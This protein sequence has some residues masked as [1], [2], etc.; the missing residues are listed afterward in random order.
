M[1][2]KLDRFFQS[3]SSRQIHLIAVS[4]LILCALLSFSIVPNKISQNNWLDTYMYTSLIYD[5]GNVVDRY[6]ATYYPTRIAHIIPA[7]VI[8][9]IFGYEFGYYIHKATF[10]SLSVV[11]VY[12]IA[13][14]FL[15]PVFSILL[16][17]WAAFNP[18]LI[19]AFLWDHYEGSALLYL[20]LAMAFSLWGLRCKKSSFGFLGVA[21]SFFALSVN[22]NPTLLAIGGSFALSWIY[23]QLKSE[24]KIKDLI[25]RVIFFLIGFCL[26]YSVMISYMRIN[27]P[28][29]G[30]FFED[31]T[32]KTVIW[33]V[34]GGAKNWFFPFS[35]LM[36]NKIYYALSPAFLL[37][38]LLFLLL[39]TRRLPNLNLLVAAIINLAVLCAFYAYSHL[40]VKSDMI[41]LF[42]YNI[43]SLPAMMF[44][45][46]ALFANVHS[47][48]LKNSP[49][50]LVTAT[51]F[52]L[53]ISWC[54]YPIFHATLQAISWKALIIIFVVLS[55]LLLL[56][57]SLIK[58]IATFMLLVVAALVPYLQGTYS[59]IHNAND[60][61]VT[62]E[63]DVYAGAINLIDIVKKYAPID[64]G[65]VGFWYENEWPTSSLNSIQST[66]LWGYSRIHSPDPDL[67]KIGMPSMTDVT[68]E[69]IFKYRFL[70]L[71]S[72]KK[73]VVDSGFKAISKLPL[74]VFKIKE[75]R[76][77]GKK[78]GY[79]YLI[80]KIKK[81]GEMPSRPSDELGLE[82]IKMDI[83]RLHSNPNWKESELVMSNDGISVKTPDKPWNYAA[84]FPLDVKSQCNNKKWCWI[85]VTF[86]DISGTPTISLFNLKENKIEFETKL[87]SKFDY[88]EIFFQL[89]EPE[90]Y[91]HLLIRNSGRDSA[92]EI[93]IKN[94]DLITSRRR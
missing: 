4:F 70:V 8:H 20:L 57:N 18:Q 3:L 87:K 29:Y 40:V 94:I 21:G 30:V 26:C 7:S 67:D 89:S 77:Q 39:K 64:Y 42:Y 14:A 85:R 6:G 1:Y 11:A 27:Y 12:F 93:G 79:D 73:E 68:R 16:G 72:E 23:L 91:T 17:V 71:M 13:S 80:L 58:L 35:K 37:I 61:V 48:E 78:F 69:N 56:K 83:S 25:L 74:I 22:C 84:L 9:S 52:L 5:Y 92:S 82:T 24:I 43:Y 66:F 45:F 60:D 47:K 63:K 10:I 28:V 59:A 33:G 90:K 31:V 75:G 49:I 2:Q 19:R 38:S 50:Y 54:F 36:E 88:R 32:W 76:F 46:I 51:V 53:L 81:P 86:G 34:K 65:P 62:T 41:G 44:G 15:S 55:I